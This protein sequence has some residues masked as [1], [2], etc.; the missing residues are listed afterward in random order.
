MSQL[1]NKLR[2]LPHQEYIDA[3]N[4][5]EQ[6]FEDAEDEQKALDKL[7][8]PDKIAARILADFADEAPA[9]SSFK[10]LWIII[11]SLFAAP[12]A[13]PIAIVLGFIAIAIIVTIIAIVSAVIL[14]G[15]AIIFVGIVGGIASLSFIFSSF[16]T[17]LYFV[18]VG[19]L[20]LSLGVLFIHY[21]ICLIK[22][23]FKGLNKL[24]SKILRRSSK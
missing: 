9:K 23:I 2:K 18:G 6:Y 12:I 8:S 10:V 24:F 13:I 3:I 21:T 11:L 7:Q 1:K 20:T 14:S 16:P 19:L 22:I 5:Y 17:T 4:Y 15:G